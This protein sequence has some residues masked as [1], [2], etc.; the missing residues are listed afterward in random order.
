MS[1][2]GASITGFEQFLLTQLAR[3]NQSSVASAIRLS[4]GKIVNFPKDDPSA[5]FQIHRF[6]QQQSIVNDLRANI[7]VAATV[8]A[9][10]QKTVDEIRTQLNTIR[11]KLVEDEN[12]T[13]TQAQRDANQV[14]IDAAIEK[15]RSLARTS[16]NG[17]R[18]LDGSS[19]HSFSGLNP[20]QIKKIN[21]LS[22]YDDTV[23]SGTVTTPATQAIVTY[24]GLLGN[25]NG[26]ATFTLTGKRGSSTISVTNGEALAAAR[27]RIN[28][29]SHKTGITAS[30]T[31]DV[32]TFTTVDYG[33]AATIGINVTSGTFTT[34]GTYAG[35][36]A[37]VTI[38]GKSIPNS[39]VDG[40]LVSYR[41]YGVNVQIDLKAGF[42]GALASVTISDD[43]VAKF[44]LS[45]R[46]SERTPFA[47]PPLFPNV[48]GGVSGIVTDVG[49]GGSLAGLGTKTSAAIRVI[50][51][52]LAQ[53][54]VIDGR[55]DAFADVT[56]ASS[57]RLMKEFSTQLQTS[58]DNINAVD[59]D[60]ESLILAKNKGLTANTTYA[61][62]VLQQQQEYILNIFKLMAQG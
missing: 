25:I 35:T 45:T 51:E 22:L 34:A 15:I 58:L 55:I 54:T 20:A 60:A 11:T 27:D 53:M 16:I 5:F 57:S 19:D 24:T 46:A 32:L 8:G 10:S 38:N 1:R 28:N 41:E 47:V 9:E 43:N 29:V 17:R 36:D 61:M 4:T 18:Y 37:V 30:V 42:V 39:D 33:D 40:N 7:E 13:L 21:V 2:I 59:E 56:V 3:I 44:A 23:I 6:E 48:L 26:S 49:S 12:Q 62:T 50:D 31:G 14:L 52:A